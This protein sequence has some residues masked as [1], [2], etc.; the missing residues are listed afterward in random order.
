MVT[1]EELKELQNKTEIIDNDL[2]ELDE[3]IENQQ[4]KINDLEKKLNNILELLQKNNIN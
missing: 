4:K 3:I 1:I 2:F